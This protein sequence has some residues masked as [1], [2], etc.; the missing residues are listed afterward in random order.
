MQNKSINASYHAVK[1]VLKQLNNYVHANAHKQRKRTRLSLH[2]D[3]AL[4]ETLFH[5][6]FKNNTI[7]VTQV[8][9]KLNR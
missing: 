2:F 4:V 1:R 9:A 6:S 7:I 3:V 8:K 5:C